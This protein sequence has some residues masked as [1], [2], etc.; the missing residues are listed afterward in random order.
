MT[1][2]ILD[3]RQASVHFGGV[4]AVDEVNLA[5]GAGSTHAIIGPNGAGKTTL[6]NAI[7]GLVPLS[8][9]EVLFDGA[10]LNKL[11]ARQ[12]ARLGVVRTFQNPALIDALTVRENIQVGLYTQTKSSSFEEALGLPR[13]LRRE[14]EA[15]ARADAVLEE[16]RIPVEGSTPVGA[17]PL[18]LRKAV[19]IARAWVAKP[20]LLLLDEPTAGLDES[21]IGEIESALA[22]VKGEISVVVIAHHLDFVMR[23]ADEVTVLEFGRVIANGPPTE[24]RSD[25][26][27]IAAYIGTADDD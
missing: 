20:K 15:R 23:L 10:P 7:S 27:V 4:V 14:R 12:R 1:G 3:V 11:R 24:V 22:R 16:L 19:D 9:G 18:G 25:P 5:V 17:L 21:E 26:A 2:S 13:A 6:L 8:G